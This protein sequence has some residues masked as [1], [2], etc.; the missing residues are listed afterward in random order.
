MTS[1]TEII[2]D[3]G[4]GVNMTK[5]HH[6]TGSFVDSVE[7]SVDDSFSGSDISQH[8]RNHRDYHNLARNGANSFDALYYM[9]A[10]GREER[11]LPAILFYSLIGKCY[12]E[13]L[14]SILIINTC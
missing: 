1:R 13:F 10:M 5:Y 11:D 7:H 9:K 6:I 8:H 12:G 3:G 14:L 2:S 4:G